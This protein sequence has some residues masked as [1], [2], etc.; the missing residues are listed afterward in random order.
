MRRLIAGVAVAGVVASIAVLAQS[1][2]DIDEES[3]PAPAPAPATRIP[4]SAT[5]GPQP[6]T[7]V[8][9]APATSTSTAP[10]PAPA[11][12]TATSTAQRPYL[13][14][15]NTVEE[16]SPAGAAVL[17]RASNAYTSLKSLK[18]DFTQKRDNPLLGSTRISRGTLYQKRPDRFLMKFSEPAG[19]VIVSD[20][21]YFWLYYPSA[22]KRQVIRA[23][24]QT[25]A[26][27]GV[28]LQAQFLGDPLTRFTHTYHG[29]ETIDGRV[30]HV[31]TMVPRQNAGYRSLKV[32]IDDRDALVRRFV[33]TENNGLVQ[34]FT[35]S[36]LVVNPALSNDLFRFTPPA[37]A[38]II[39]NP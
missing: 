9:P 23:P 36:G 15:P 12:S 21:R 3:G 27:G 32:W 31:L 28:D 2:I 37:N 29:R 33:L 20:G 5:R 18:A 13:E 14:Q 34:E 6:A 22:D 10:A 19:D 35:L 1:Q 11:T 30:T 16:Q 17:R 7:R 26:A 38:N 8:V 4:Q 39:D 24:A 25:G